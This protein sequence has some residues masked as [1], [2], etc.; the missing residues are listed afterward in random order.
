MVSITSGIVHFYFPLFVHLNSIIY[1]RFRRRSLQKNLSIT[2]GILIPVTGRKHTLKRCW[3]LNT[4]MSA[5]SKRIRSWKLRTGSWGRS[6]KRHMISWGSLQLTEWI[7]WN[8]SCGVLVSGYSRRWQGWVGKRLSK[9]EG[10]ESASSSFVKKYV[11]KIWCYQIY[12]N[13]LINS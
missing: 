6:W 3:T 7:Y 2:S 12:I 9:R 5:W 10:C 8:I 1:R 4:R 13:S 11:G